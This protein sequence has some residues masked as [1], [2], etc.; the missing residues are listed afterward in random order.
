[1]YNKTTIKET[2]S[3]PFATTTTTTTASATIATIITPS[4]KSDTPMKCHAV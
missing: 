3:S 4:P 1:M 2:T